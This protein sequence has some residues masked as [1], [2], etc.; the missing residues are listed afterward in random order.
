MVQAR[1]LND[2]LRHGDAAQT[3]PAKHQKATMKFIIT[4]HGTKFSREIH[5][6]R[7]NR[8]Q[9]KCVTAPF[10]EYAIKTGEWEDTSRYTG[11]ILR[12]LR[13]ERG[14]G[15]IKFRGVRRAA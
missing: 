6:N 1:I 8:P 5:H 9:P 2:S 12:V 11:T 4:A 7:R 3:H 10:K 14:C 13:K 15:R